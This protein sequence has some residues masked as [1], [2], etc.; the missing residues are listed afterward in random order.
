M[1]IIRLLT[2]DV[3]QPTATPT[4]AV[5]HDTGMLNLQSLWDLNKMRFANRLQNMADTRLPKSVFGTTWVGRGS[6]LSLKNLLSKIWIRLIPDATMRGQEIPKLDQLSPVEFK[7][8]VLQMVATRD[9]TAWKRII[10]NK[11]KLALYTIVL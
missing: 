9:D 8:T 7:S 2:C 11:P 6:N 1:F 5:L 3:I 10:R 4:A